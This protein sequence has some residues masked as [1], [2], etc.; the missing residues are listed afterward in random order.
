MNIS[1]YKDFKITSSNYGSQLSQT[2]RRDTLY[3]AH[4][5][6][7]ASQCKQLGLLH[8]GARATRSSQITLGEDLF[9][10]VFIT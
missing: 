2:N 3:E 5:E 7:G 10:A 1:D 4:S 9:N 8:S 6:F